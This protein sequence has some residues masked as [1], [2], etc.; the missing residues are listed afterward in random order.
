MIL[1]SLVVACAML[2]STD[3]LHGPHLFS[4]DP[5]GCTPRAGVGVG[6]LA[7]LWCFACSCGLHICTLAHY[8][9]LGAG[10]AV[11]L[12]ILACSCDFLFPCSCGFSFRCS[13]GLCISTFWC[14][15]A[16]TER[17]MLRELVA[18]VEV[19]GRGQTRRSMVD[20]LHGLWD[21]RRSS[22]SKDLWSNFWRSTQLA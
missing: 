13:C 4:R 7:Q 9:W 19:G 12:G 10:A 2:W 15:S 22:G 16:F 21:S 17:V 14:V 5:H 3:Q 18:S 1:W 20:V 6:V 8:L 11:V